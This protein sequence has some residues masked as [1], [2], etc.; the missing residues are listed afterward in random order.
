MEKKS[1]K[2]NLKFD[3]ERLESSDTLEDCGI[4]DEDM[5]EAKCL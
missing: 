5:L 3:G 1:V 4:E 2:V